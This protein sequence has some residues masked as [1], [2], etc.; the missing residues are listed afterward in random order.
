M[1]QTLLHCNFYLCVLCVSLFCSHSFPAQQQHVLSDAANGSIC[2]Q[3][4]WPDAEI[5]TF[6]RRQQEADYWGIKRVHTYT[7]MRTHMHRGHH[8]SRIWLLSKSGSHSEWTCLSDWLT[9]TLCYHGRRGG[10]NR[11][12]VNLIHITPPSLSR[13]SIKGFGWSMGIT[14]L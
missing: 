4:P 14:D 12:S 8:I 1:T 10:A 7:H 5:P 13:F 9:K 6:M 3:W 11:V 2:P